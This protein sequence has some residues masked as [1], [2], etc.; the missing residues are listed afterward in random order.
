MRGVGFEQPAHV[1]VGALPEPKCKTDAALQRV[2]LHSRFLTSEPAHLP[3]HETGEESRSKAYLVGAIVAL[4][5]VAAGVLVAYTSPLSPGGANGAQ[6]TLFFTSTQT[7][8]TT[9]VSFSTLTQ[10]ASSQT[11]APGS[12]ST[13]KL[14]LAPSGVAFDSANG[15]TYVVLTNASAIQVLNSK[16][17]VV[18][19]ITLPAGAGPTGVAVNS[20]TNMVYA[21]DSKS[22]NVSII[23]GSRNLLVTTIAA[24]KGPYGVAVN[25]ATNVIWVGSEND[26]VISAI[27]GTTNTIIKG[28]TNS[29]TGIGTV[30]V[31]NAYSVAVDPTTNKVYVGAYHGKGNTSA[32][33][34]V[35]GSKNKVLQSYAM[36]G[37][38]LTSIVFDQG[39]GMLYVANPQKNLVNVFDPSKSAFV[40]NLTIPHP[41]SLSLD[42]RTGRMLATNSN[43]GTVTVINTST[44]AVS[45]TLQVGN[46]PTGTDFNPIASLVYVTNNK[47]NTLTAIPEQLL[48]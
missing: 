38:Q 12:P 4:V 7:I 35:D 3:L 36:S 9:I 19:N 1:Y 48:P 39:N 34:V 37:N 40:A 25:P 21:T 10:S 41:W 13:I 23:D 6:A 42:P 16:N 2:Q 30:G 27:N 5:G 33:T 26:D 18:A 15:L 24:P 14:G 17:V 32:L 8:S 45:G 29:T 22:S 46:A 44:N 43:G 20:N 11:S 47:D 31:D 28:A